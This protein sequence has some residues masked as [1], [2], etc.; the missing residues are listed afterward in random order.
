MKFCTYGAACEAVALVPQHVAVGI[1]VE[2]HHH[3]VDAVLHRRRHLLRV[4]QES[5]VAGE[6]DHR[7]VRLGHLGPQR[8]RVGIAQVARV[9]RCDESPW[10]IH[11]EVGPAV[12]AQL[13]H[14]GNQNAIVGHGG[15]HGGQEGLLRLHD[16]AG[17]LALPTLR[18]NLG[19][20]VGPGQGDLRHLG[21][22]RL[23][24]QASVAVHPVGVGVIA[25]QFLRVHV[26]LD[27]LLSAQP[28]RESE[29]S[30][31]G[32]H[33]V[34]AA[35]LVG[36]RVVP[37]P[38]G[39]QR[40]R[41]PVGNDALGLGGGDDRHLH[42]FGQLPHCIRRARRY[43]AAARP[44]QRVLR[45]RQH[46]GSLGDPPAVRSYPARR[47]RLEQ[48]NVGDFSQRFRRNLD[49]H[50]TGP[51]VLQVVECLVDSLRNFGRVH[52][53]ARELGHRLH[54]VQLVVH[55]VEHP[56]VDADQVALDLARHH[57]HRRRSCIGSVQCGGGV[58]QPWAWHHQRGPDAAAR[59]GVAVGHVGSGLLVPGGDEPD[60][61]LVVEGVHGVV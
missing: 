16:D 1:V 17:L 22:Q 26:Y 12:V 60:P 52:G 55:L 31:H 44:D 28:E 23:Q 18:R 21:E 58:E 39:A 30:P 56:P 48:F 49:L 50:R 61:R 43:G 7:L 59:P 38:Q 20:A 19:A 37:Q 24:R 51:T 33:Q 9:R 13:R 53:S 41:V 15:A 35:V 5:A 34:M 14:S 46:P 32:Q 3:N 11:R 42:V 8:S 4:V 45:R 47:F 6:R 10:L 27:H 25:A 57:H 40:Q 2:H 29:A 36:H 54:D